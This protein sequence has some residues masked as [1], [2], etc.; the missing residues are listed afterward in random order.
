MKNPVIN[1]FISEN[2]LSRKNKMNIWSSGEDLGQSFYM[3]VQS[4]AS[5]PINRS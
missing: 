3:N 2:L 4:N 1:A 5:K